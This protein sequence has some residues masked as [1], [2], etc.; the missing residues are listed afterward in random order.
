MGWKAKITIV[1][2][3]VL[4]LV[5]QVRRQRCKLILTVELRAP[6]ASCVP[7]GAYGSGS[8]SSGSSSLMLFGLFMFFRFHNM[9]LPEAGNHVE[10]RD[11]GPCCT[12]SC[13]DCTFALNQLSVALF[14]SLLLFDAL[15][16]Q[17]CQA[18]I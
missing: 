10:L 15:A 2:T 6:V 14:K 5:L 3:G 13:I 4:L 7:P 1:L 12:Q 17:N 8:L 11:C 16:V 18:E 9:F